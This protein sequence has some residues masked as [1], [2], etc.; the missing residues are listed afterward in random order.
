MLK[1]AMK[2]MGAKGGK[3]AA[4][5]MTPAQRRAR[6]QKAATASAK[7]RSAKAK[8]K[9]RQSDPATERKGRT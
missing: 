6:A 1:Q 7:V 3:A 8:A 9:G 5:H 4:A 2:L